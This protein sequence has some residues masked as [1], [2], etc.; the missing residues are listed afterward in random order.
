MGNLLLWRSKITKWLT[1]KDYDIWKTIFLVFSMVLT[2]FVALC[3]ERDTFIF[4]TAAITSVAIVWSLYECC[5]GTATVQIDS[6]RV[7]VAW[8]F[9]NYSL[10]VIISSLLVSKKEWGTEYFGMFFAFIASFILVITCSYISYL[11]KLNNDKEDSSIFRNKVSKFNGCIFY[12][13]CSVFFLMFLASK[14]GKQLSNYKE[15]QRIEKQTTLFSQEKWYTVT[16]WHTEILNGNTIYIIKCAKGRV[17]I[18][19]SKYPQIRDINSNT[20]I[21]YIKGSEKGG[22]II[23]E[24]LEIKN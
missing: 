19:P 14:E 7:C 13:I 4:W 23:P 9:I 16:E 15:K 22:V 11:L 1:L 17:G 2:Y 8:G 24:K 21:K 18:Y 6:L 12:I 3:F 10:F 20:K 5:W